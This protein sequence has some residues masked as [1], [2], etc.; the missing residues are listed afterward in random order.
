MIIY[1]EADDLFSD[2]SFPFGAVLDNLKIKKIV[3]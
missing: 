3:P 1:D 2:Q